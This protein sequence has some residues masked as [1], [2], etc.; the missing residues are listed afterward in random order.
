MATWAHDWA[1]SSRY[2]DLYYQGHPRPVSSVYSI[3]V[4]PNL[5]RQESRDTWYRL[6]RLLSRPS[7]AVSRTHESRERAVLDRV[8][9]L[10]ADP[11]VKSNSLS[12]ESYVRTRV[13]L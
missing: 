4:S 3:Y 2:V 8:L 13:G 1:W 9:L 10:G 12:V 5:F 11:S 7:D 6:A